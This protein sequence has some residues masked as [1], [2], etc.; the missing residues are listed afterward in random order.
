MFQ[1]E[2]RILVDQLSRRYEVTRHRLGDGFGQGQQLRPDG[3]VEIRSGDLVGNCRP[4]W[5]PGRVGRPVAPIPPVGTEPSFP[6]RSPV[7]VT[8]ARIGGGV[9]PRRT[10]SARIRTRP[11]GAVARR[12]RR[13]PV[14]TTCA[15]VCAT[16]AVPI[17]TPEARTLAAVGVL[18]ALAAPEP[19]SG[20]TRSTSVVTAAR[21]PAAETTATTIVAT[22]AGTRTALGTEATALPVIAPAG[23]VPV[24]ATTRVTITVRVTATTA[25]VAA[26]AGTR[27]TVGTE[28]TT[29]PVI[30]PPR[31]VPEAASPLVAVAT[32]VTTLATETTATPVI[33]ARAGTRTTVATETTTTPVV[34]A[35]TGTRTTVATETTTTP[36][37]TAG[38]G[39]RTTPV[40]TLGTETAA[41]PVIAARAGTRTTVATETT[42]TPVVG[43]PRVV[44][45]TARALVAVA[46]PMISGALASVP[47]VV[48]PRSAVTSWAVVTSSGRLVAAFP[49][50]APRTRPAWAVARAGV[51][52]PRA[53]VAASGTAAAEATLPVI[54]SAPVA[55]TVAE[56]STAAT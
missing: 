40:T 38:T 42:T 41:T 32:P 25:V 55:T 22:G 4:L 10:S 8:P 27:T 49:V 48:A 34:T 5:L 13:V 11:L 30:A 3:G 7:R 2:G 26:R 56:A 6:A 31:V 46:T 17:R 23:I 12:A 9:A 24:T 47:A 14:V 44:P 35:G 15:A 1:S 19:A 53:E 50:P 21:L 37:V 16:G 20:P 43:P 33:A 39:T 45:E 51:L 36:V 18:A 28:T 54:A 29:T 52:A